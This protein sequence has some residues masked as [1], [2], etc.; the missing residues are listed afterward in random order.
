MYPRRDPN[1]TGVYTTAFPVHLTGSAVAKE[2]F[3]VRNCSFRSRKGGVLEG[4]KSLPRD[5]DSS[6]RQVLCDG[7][8]SSEHQSSSSPSESH[9]LNIA[10]PVS[11]LKAY[12]ACPFCRGDSTATNTQR[13]L[14]IA[15]LGNIYFGGQNFGAVCP[16]SG[17]PHLTPH[18]EQWI[19]E[20]SGQEPRFR[21]LYSGGAP[22]SHFSESDL[23]PTFVSVQ[24][25][26]KQPGLPEKWILHSLVS[27]FTNS[28]FS[29]VFPLINPVL[30]E[31][32]ARLA[33]SPDEMEPLL[34][35]ITAKACVLAF[36]SLASSHCPNANG[37]SHVDIDS[38]ARDAQILLSDIIED[39]SITT[40]QTIL[41]L[42][43][44]ET[45]CGRLQAS[46]MY[47]ALACRTVFT[48][49]GHTVMVST[50]TDRNLT[51]QEH[52]DRHLRRL[53]WL[54][55]V[56]DKEISLRNGQPPAIPDQFCDLT[57]P[58][59]YAQSRFLPTE[60]GQIQNP[61]LPGD[62]RLS[63]LKSKAVQLLYSHASLRKSD[64]ELLKTIRELDEELE[65]WRTSIPEAFSP[66]LSLEYDT[67]LEGVTS[68]S[69]NMLLIELHLDYHFLLNTIHCASSRCITR[70]SSDPQQISV[71]VQSS[72]DLS[73]EA[74]R[75]TIVYLSMSASRLAGEAFWFFVFYPLSALMNLFF[76]ILQNPGHALAVHDMELLGKTSQII[77][78]MPIRRVTSH[79]TEY[80]TKMDNLV[81]ELCRLSKCAIEKHQA[82]LSTY[83]V[84]DGM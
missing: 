5:N 65:T 74:S 66:N 70:G 51:V 8:Q 62:L 14:G 79:E 27:A 33:Y 37:A 54:C 16:R 69:T 84:N 12:P 41:M 30:F 82:M 6:H 19:R 57:L 24:A 67:R 23:V 28:D 2:N 32:T 52:E 17:I 10:G 73:V 25:Q 50:P 46:S 61:W 83:Q 15:P 34:E 58:E 78:S 75:S 48:L 18:C 1:A 31:E 59:G 47:H 13:R 71:G 68:M 63:I 26:V 55:Y 43:L 44:H 60:Q 36:V 53:F 45:L 49:G 11:T 72:F 3:H 77:R 56:L 29:L 22:R 64:A 40:L 7:F 20:R 38:C 42:L 39:S 4:Q 80:L 21:H 76:N 35:R 9:L 81:A